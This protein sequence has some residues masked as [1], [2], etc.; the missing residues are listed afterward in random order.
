MGAVKP[1]DFDALKPVHIAGTKGKGSTAAFISSILMQYL[2]SSLPLSNSK[3]RKVGLY[4][5]PHLRSVRERIQINNT[6]LSEDEFARYFFE[7]WDRLEAAASR[8]GLLTDV[9]AKPVYFRFLTLMALHTYI[10]EGVDT[11]IIEA[12]IGGEYDSTN[13]IVHPTVV[14]ISSLGIDHV[15]MLGHTI[16]EI[17]WHKAG[18]IKS[19]TQAFTVP[20]PPKAMQVLQERASESGVK[21]AVVERHADLEEITLGLAAD[22]QK[23]NASLAIAVAAAHLQALGFTDLPANVITSPLPIEFRRGLEQV[24]WAGRCETRREGKITWFIDGGHTAES[25]KVAGQWYADEI[26]AH[27]RIRPSS[28]SSS[29]SPPLPPSPRVLVFNQQTRDAAA[30]AKILHQTLTDAMGGKAH[31]PF[32]HVI[33]C[34]NKTFR[35]GGYKADLVS[36]NTDDSD[37]EELRVQKRLASAWAEMEGDDDGGI[38]VRVLRTIEDAVQFV[39][40]LASND[41]GRGVE[42]V[43]VLV[44]GSLHL[45]GGLI[46]VLEVHKEQSGSAP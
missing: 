1:V 38:D 12:G 2:K 37:V 44:T 41:D 17:A 19:G 24:Q 23:S 13:I 42:E 5:S 35:N 33:F 36:L 39:R 45:V 22:F 14:G 11:A 21:L 46:E 18:I 9:S 28:S 7:V 25:I 3:L 10:R 6:P 32:T 43:M 40:S 31:R 27:Q 30:L 4:T 26:S 34:S 15:A 20:Q 16:E 29:S 8:N